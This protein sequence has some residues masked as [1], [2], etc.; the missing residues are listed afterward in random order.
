MKKSTLTFAFITLVSLLN[1]SSIQAQNFMPAFI[2]LIILG[3]VVLRMGTSVR[4]VAL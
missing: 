3:W 4:Q 2:H 1:T